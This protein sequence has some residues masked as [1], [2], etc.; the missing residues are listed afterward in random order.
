M[1][2]ALRLDQ[3]C[4]QTRQDRSHDLS[5]RLHALFHS[6]PSSP[7]KHGARDMGDTSG[8]NRRISVDHKHEARTRLRRSLELH[9]TD[10]AKVVARKVDASP[11]TVEAHRRE[12]PKSWAQMI[13]YC[14]AYPAFAL[15]VV[16]AMGLDIDRDR[17]AYSMFLQLQ[18]QVRGE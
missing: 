12:I 3:S 2:Q 13:A 18:K 15:D 5:N 4:V 9:V 11:D 1:G 6:S 16:E 17:E 8:T 7:H 10:P 14:R